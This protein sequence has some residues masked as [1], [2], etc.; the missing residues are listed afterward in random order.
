MST[1]ALR[2]EIQADFDA[3][4]PARARNRPGQHATPAALARAITRLA[5]AAHG[6]GPV[7]LLEPSVGTGA[8]F[9]ALVAES[10]ATPAAGAGHLGVELDPELAEGAALLWG[11]AG[12]TVRRGDFTA[13]A[14]QGQRYSLILA[15]PP[16]A[17][18]HHLDAATK[19]RL[20]AA[21]PE[22]ALSGLAGLHLYFVLLAH[23]WLAPGGVAAWLLPGEWLETATGAALR[24][25]LARDV[26][27]LQVHRFEATDLQF[28]EA[29]VSSVVVLLRQGAPP[30]GHRARFSVGPDPADP[31]RW[32]DHPV[33]AL[34]ARARWARLEQ[35]PDP[36]GEYQITLNQMFDIKRGVAT[37]ANRFFIRDLD[38]WDALGVP[39]AFLRPV[40]PG[41]RRLPFPH[42]PARPDGWPDLRPRLA[43]LDIRLSPEALARAHPRLFAWLHGPE[44]E[45]ARQTWLARHRAPWY[46]QERR[47]PAPVLASY[48]GRP[49]ADRPAVRLY[50][51]PTRAVAPNVYMGLYPRPELGADPAQLAALVEA[52]NALPPGHLAGHGRTYAGGLS[53]LEP[54]DLGGVPIEAALVAAGLR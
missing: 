39:R 12:L 8:F 27:L 38:A 3:S 18:H 29:L 47:D 19:A 25:H 31:A 24:A 32:A 36:I 53:K 28:G 2:Q 9:S 40:L 45:A 22:H 46:R 30:P 43:L 42:V 17:R 6:P 5:L 50:T 7:R 49:R 10:R 21:L 48:M 1:E 52:I 35:P 51:N 11:G 26:T 15:N 44:G 14:P 16:Y 54:G 23:R 13:M 4:R 33:G 34:A 41:V 20:R 37:G